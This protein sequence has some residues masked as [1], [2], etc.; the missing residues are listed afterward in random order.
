MYQ[1]GRILRD[2]ISFG[3][4][5]LMS[6]TFS[7]CSLSISSIDVKVV[8]LAVD[9]LIMAQGSHIDKIQFR[10]VEQ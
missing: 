10:K 9:N 3:N 4:T 2:C 6:R 7:F 5:S 1:K 8:L